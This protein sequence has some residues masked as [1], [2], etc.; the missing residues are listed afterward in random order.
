M[1]EIK[2]HLRLNAPFS[3][4]SCFF[5]GIELKEYVFQGMHVLADCRCEQCGAPFWHTL[6]VGHARQLPVAIT[7]DGKKKVTPAENSDWL[8]GPLWDSLFKHPS[9]HFPMERKVLIPGKSREAV[10][11]NCLDSCYGHVYTKLWNCT[12]VMRHF[13]EKALIVLLPVQL[14]WLV[15]EGV[16][17]IWTVQAPLAQLDRYIENLDAFVKEGIRE[18]SSVVLS[19]AYPHLRHEEE[20]SEKLVKT[21][22]FDLTHFSSAPSQITFVLREDRF[23]H[24]SRADMLLY[25]ACLKTKS[26][27]RFRW[28]F[29]RKQ[30]Q[31]VNKAAKLLRRQLGDVRILATGIG[32]SGNVS[33]EIDDQR[34]ATVSE[35]IEMEWCALYAGSQLV[36]GVHGSNMLI[37]S[38]LAAGFIDILPRYKIPHLTEDTVLPYENRYSLFL[39]RHLDHWVSPSLLASHAASMIRDFPRLYN[40]TEQEL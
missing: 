38:S 28:Y 32:K 13:P 1:V 34:T 37:P 15:P 35:A 30:N 2:P 20:T 9:V 16:A 4:P 25:M 12:L 31:L 40:N 26:L 22:R 17:E 8:A 24:A 39:G 19:P 14:A 11:L 27:P 36:I 5:E 29:V 3:C 23:W 18:Y 21:R 6:P 7:K 33:E 10:I